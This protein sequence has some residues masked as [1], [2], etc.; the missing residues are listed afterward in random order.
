M[1]TLKS[2][3]ASRRALTAAAAIAVSVS[4]S[5]NA[6]AAFT[7]DSTN[8]PDATFRAYLSTLTGV[9][10]GGT[11]TDAIIA[12]VTEIDVSGNSNIKSLVGAEKFLSLQSIKC[13]D[14]D[15]TGGL[16]LADLRGASS[17]NTT[18]TYLD[19][20]NNPNMGNIGIGYCRGLV[21]IDCSNC[22]LS[23]GGNLTIGMHTTLE[24]LKC[25]DNTITNFGSY[26]LGYSGTALKYFEM[27]NNTS[28]TTIDLSKSSKL[29]TLDLS[30]CTALNY[31]N[32]TA[33]TALTD[34]DIHGCTKF[35]ST[36]TS[37]STTTGKVYWDKCTK[38]KNINIENCNFSTVNVRSLVA[39]ETLRAAHNAV[40]GWTSS[41]YYSTT[42]NTKLQSVDFSYNALPASVTISG[43]AAL[44]SLDVSHNTSITTLTAENNALTDIDITGCTSLTTLSLS[45]NGFTD[46]PVCGSATVTSLNM[47]FNG[48]TSLANFRS[49]FPNVATLYIGGSNPFGST[50]TFT[51]DATLQNLYLKSNTTLQSLN[52]SGCSALAKAN[53]YNNTALTTL[54]LSGTQLAA[55][56]AT[57]ANN[58]FA[59]LATNALCIG[60]CTALESVNLAN[61]SFTGTFDM[62]SYSSLAVLD[63]SGTTVAKATLTNCAFTSLSDLDLPNTTWYLDLDGNRLTSLNGVDDYTGLLRLYASNNR[64]VTA[65]MTGNATI[66]SLFLKNNA[67]MTSID[68]TGNALHH[69][70]LEGSTALTSIDLSDNHFTTT[71]T[72]TTPSDYYETVTN[73]GHLYIAN[74]TNVTSLNV[75][76]NSIGDNNGGLGVH[77]LTG[78]QTLSARDNHLTSVSQANLGLS[79]LLSADYS[80]NSLTSFVLTGC[81][82]IET[83]NLSDNAFTTYTASGFSHLASLDMSDNASLTTLTANNNALTSLDVG[84]CTALTTLTAN[85][86]ALTAIDVSDCAVLATLNVENNL[87]TGIDISDTNINHLDLLGNQL[88]SLDNVKV[89]ATTTIL[90]ASNNPL[91]NI[92]GINGEDLASVERLYI[93][94]IAGLT[95]LT[96]HGNTTLKSLF[97]SGQGLTT[98]TLTT[99]DLS[100]NQLRHLYL[101]G[102]TALTDVNISNNRFTTLST[103]TTTSQYYENVTSD[104][105]VY[106]ANSTNLVTLRADTCEFTSFA[107]STFTKLTTL[108]LSH[109]SLSSIN[110]NSNTRLVNLYLNNNQFA[111]SISFLRNTALEHVELQNNA[112]W[113]LDFNNNT[114][115]LYL[116]ISNQRDANDQPT[117]HATALHRREADYSIN[118]HSKGWIWLQTMTKL[119]Y[120]N[121]N[122]NYMY[123]LGLNQLVSL[124]ELYADNSHYEDMLHVDFNPEA[125]KGFSYSPNLRRISMRNSQLKQVQFT[126]T[127][128]PGGLHHLEYVDL[129]GNDLTPNH[130]SSEGTIMTDPL[131][132]IGKCNIDTLLLSDN[133]HLRKIDL[134]E[135]HDLSYL[136]VKGCIGTDTLFVQDNLNLESIVGFDELSSLTTLYAYNMGKMTTFDLSPISTLQTAWLWNDN[137]TSLKLPSTKSA[138]KDLRANDNANLKTVSLSGYNQLEHIQL[139]RTG[140]STLA[141]SSKSKLT[142][143]SLAQTNVS[144]LSLSSCTKLTYLDADS[145]KFTAIDLSK[146]KLLETFRIKNNAIHTLDLAANTALTT[147][148]YSYN[149]VN[150]IDLSTCT[151]L[152][153]LTDDHNG[154]QIEAMCAPQGSG[155]VYYFRLDDFE[156]AENFIGA[157]TDATHGISAT[158]A[159]D[160]FDLGNVGEWSGGHIYQSQAWSRLRHG[161][162][163]GTSLVLDDVTDEGASVSGS[164]S[165]TYNNNAPAGVSPTS[166]FYLDYTA[167]KN[168]VTGI[169]DVNAGELTV[170]GGYGTITISSPEALTIEVT[171]M[172]GR[173]LRVADI[174]TGD[175]TID[176]FVPGIYI[177]AGQK[178]IVK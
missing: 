95:S 47:D 34:L 131:Q 161:T 67:L 118:G 24:T 99:L 32:L 113:H 109:N 23:G 6:Y 170:A 123:A 107:P 176:G 165:Y 54:N 59:G 28:M 122:D 124:E 44:E 112:L 147:L 84:G 26:A 1:K 7:L 43:L 157:Q 9:A 164:V 90:D 141:C 58:T 3:F 138:L 19:C 133:A 74:L 69:L 173:T 102:Q 145:C 64:F 111:D 49:R 35:N 143:L 62:A 134:S 52:L 152:T 91:T 101:H 142:Y 130:I 82:N 169:A 172:S 160:G 89:A 71:T 83:L 114:E 76:G 51:G 30:G 167:D 45:T 136:D 119:K 171:D 10:E 94:D 33:Q 65:S 50:L 13:Y 86:N 155:Y 129:R 53:L 97:M 151:A 85:N 38:L 25:S 17:T 16:S 153:S 149:H 46:F 139:D 166:T 132:G 117:M 120:F 154:R 40:N 175:T 5:F 162:G 148:D 41:G 42:A 177:V 116:D 87:F 115:M 37:A 21:Y 75:D 57:N 88:T 73:S 15:I 127:A 100:R 128:N 108:G 11:V 56:T 92:D 78:L 105:K 39:L 126:T 2:I 146:N 63:L 29:L 174:P 61:T 156:G 137:L 98:K 150:A 103:S 163:S 48:L 27:R 55:L 22:G 96:L 125:A 93:N 106:L 20:H 66:K 135:N 8:V 80:G 31:L 159:D 144:S 36:V 70:T 60:G 104:G 168:V 110:I 72:S 12:T 4:L 121:V 79:S 140:I 68:I 158:L 81:T 77:T 14:C 18:L 178:V